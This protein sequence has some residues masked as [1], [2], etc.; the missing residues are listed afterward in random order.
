MAAIWFDADP[1]SN[2][3]LGDDE[4]VTCA[5]VFDKLR[6]GRTVATLFPGG[7]A[8]SNCRAIIRSDD[9]GV[10]TFELEESKH[11]PAQKLS[12]LLQLEP[13]GA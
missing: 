12:D 13:P 5:D 6:N 10:E 4:H 9:R 2:K 1:H 11:H 8:G 3:R 7:V